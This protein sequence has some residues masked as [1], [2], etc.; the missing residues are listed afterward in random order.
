V[1][2]I[3]RRHFFCIDENKH[4]KGINSP[5]LSKPE[6]KFVT[7]D[8]YIIELVKYRIQKKRQTRPQAA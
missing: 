4:N 7:T 5:L 3:E 1:L 2:N 6:T 8:L